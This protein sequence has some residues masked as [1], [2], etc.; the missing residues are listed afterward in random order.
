MQ[1]NE[2][3]NLIA[4]LCSI[5]II[6][7]IVFNK[8]LPRFYLFLIALLCIILS[9]TFTI[10]EGYFFYSFFN[11]LEHLFILISGVFFLLGVITYFFK[12]EVE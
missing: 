2:L 12:K 6:L 11:F 7:F 4:D 10:I 1:I 3:L 5:P 8:N 9:H